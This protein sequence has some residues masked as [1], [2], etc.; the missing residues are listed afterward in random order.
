[1]SEATNQTIESYVNLYTKFFQELTQEYGFS[2]SISEALNGIQHISDPLDVEDVLYTM[3]GAL[4]HTKEECDTFEAVF[5]RRFLQY[6]Y[7]PKPKESSIPKKRATNSVATFV[8][9]SDDALEECRKKTQA[10]R[11]QAQADIENYRRSNRGKESVSNQQKA[12]DALREEAEQKRQAVLQ[13][14]DDCQKAVASVTLAGNRQLVDQIEQLLQKVNAETNGELAAY[15]ITERQ[16]RNSLASGT[17]QELAVSQKL[18]LSAAVLARS[19]KEASLYM[20]FIS[21][22][23]A[24]QNM[25]KSVKTSQPK[26]SEDDTVK[27]AV[28]KHGEAAEE[29]ENAKEALHK[30]EAELEKQE[31]FVLVKRE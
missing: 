1:M 22:A 4:C 13:A 31:I 18:L 19:A 11:D 23:K 9:M 5:C 3:Q 27:A 29:W 30:A 20:N 14:Y 26:V 25:A 15:R 10:N 28:K 17:S 16:L 21:L 7:A 8:D 6:S 24:F 12:V 2:F